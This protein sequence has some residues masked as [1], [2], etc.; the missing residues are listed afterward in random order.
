MARAIKSCKITGLILCLSFSGSLAQEK[1]AQT[2]F[3]FLSVGTYA[4]ATAMAE[5]ITTLEGTP[6]ALFY[7]PAGLTRS[8]STVQFSANQTSWIADIDYFSSALSVS[9][10]GG[11]AGV[12]GLSFLFVNYGTIIGT[13]VAPNEQGFIET[14]NIEPHAVQYGLGYAKA[15]SD[16]FSVGA[17]V[18]Y[19][20][21]SIGEAF[22][23][24]TDST[25]AAIDFSADVVAFDFGTLYHTG[26][27]SLKFGMSIRNFSNEVAFEREDFELPLTFRVGF[28]IDAFDFF[29]Q[30][31]E[32]QSFNIS[33]DTV[34][35]RSLNEYLSIG[36]EYQLMD[37]LA[38]RG[39]YASGQ[40]NYGLSGG[41]GI[42]TRN[43]VLDYSY[44]PFE[45]FN[46]IHRFSVQ[47]EF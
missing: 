39:G 41:L 19:V 21:Q 42:R 31:S 1:I 32:S 36:G 30:S 15:L 28:S 23:P 14:G 11:E 29:G 20:N 27:K 38:L 17:H 34:N 18:K 8:E 25:Q 40:D 12:V 26:F 47:F 46:D 43:I 45:L 13:V 22:V 10:K 24:Q 4:R 7:N 5:A 16:R 44:T 37:V 9:I 6:M 33:F 2:G 3:Q 35:P